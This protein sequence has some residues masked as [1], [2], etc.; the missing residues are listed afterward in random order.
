MVLTAPLDTE[1]IIF[2]A[3]KNIHKRP[4]GF[5]LKKRRKKLSG[6]QKDKNMV[7]IKKLDR[8][9]YQDSNHY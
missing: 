6:I 1:K 2:S 9:F 7:M 4:V 8:T 3:P 5:S